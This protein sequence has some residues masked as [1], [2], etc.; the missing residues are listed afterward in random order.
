MSTAPTFI[1]NWSD[2]LLLPLASMQMNQETVQTIVD[3]LSYV[4][5]V[6]PQMKVQK[7]LNDAMSGFGFEETVAISFGGVHLPIDTR[8]A[9]PDLVA[10]LVKNIQHITSTK[11]WPEHWGTDAARAIPIAAGF[12]A[13]STKASNYST[14]AIAALNAYARTY[15]AS[16]LIDQVVETPALLIPAMQ[17]LALDIPKDEVEGHMER[18]HQLLDGQS[19]DTPPT[20]LVPSILNILA[21]ARA[22]NTQLEMNP[23]ADT[24]SM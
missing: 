4:H 1:K 24:L 3:R 20:Q 18:V 10:D 13:V 9:I 6:Y 23:V 17:A 12:S 16:S 8:Q 7:E 2:T 22:Q 5:A 15:G 21:Q 14:V 19:Q 11:Q